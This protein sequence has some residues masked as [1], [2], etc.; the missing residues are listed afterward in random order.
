LIR[1]LLYYI[2]LQILAIHVVAQDPQFS[3]FYANPLYLGPSFAGAVEGSRLAAQYRTQWWD[4]ETPYRTYSL[5]YD[6]YFSTFNSGVGLLFLS[7]V[8]GA[9]NLGITQVALNYSYNF[10]VFNVW[11]I[12][13]GLSFSYVEQGLHGSLVY[14]DQ[15]LY[16][17]QGSADGGTSYA[18]P[19]LK[20]SRDIDAGFS[21]LVYTKKLW[22]GGTIDHLL[23]PDVGLYST[24]ESIPI[25]V[26][27][28]G[29]Y[30]FHRR[31][32]LLRPSDETM[33]FAFL[34][35]QQQNIS[36]LDIGVYWHHYP[37]VLGLWYRGIPIVNSERGDAV[38]FMAGI[39]TRN[40]NIGYSYDLTISDLL[41]HTKGSHEISLTYKFLLPERTK[42]GSV[43][44]PEF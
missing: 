34:Y 2:L 25:K 43:P 37:I 29:G 1:K 24:E 19:A 20:N 13:P 4:M 38:I 11:H 41:P 15:V 5:S 9:G 10:Q 30:E 17:K 16:R 12:R 28:Y 21:T 26:T 27:A 36:Q 39:K 6:H 3:Q 8:A 22:L 14:I 23:T 32:K 44:C 18:D 33:T 40:L 7:D 35:R 31:G 42:K